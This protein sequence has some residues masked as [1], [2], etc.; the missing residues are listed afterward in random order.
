MTPTITIKRTYTTK[1]GNRGIVGTIDG[2]SFARFIRRDESPADAVL[3]VWGVRIG[4]NER[5]GL[6]WSYGLKP[7]GFTGTFK[8]ID[9]LTVSRFDRAT[10]QPSIAIDTP[11][12][13]VYRGLSDGLYTVFDGLNRY[14]FAVEDGHLDRVHREHLRKWAQAHGWI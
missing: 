14:F 4:S 1:T 10:M 12:G 7:A 11:E 2:R 8:A 5:R 3:R 6:K 13:G 9:G